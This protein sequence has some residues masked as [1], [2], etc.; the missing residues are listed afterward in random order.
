[1]NEELEREINAM[2][3]LSHPH[4]VD[5]IG[6]TRKGFTHNVAWLASRDVTVAMLQTTSTCS[7]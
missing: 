5:I 4:V 6:Q 7:W 1:M 3:G 2:V